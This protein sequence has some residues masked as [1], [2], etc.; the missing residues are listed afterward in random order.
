M[1]IPP[2]S[3]HERPPIVACHSVVKH[4]PRSPPRSIA[5][6]LVQFGLVS[7]PPPPKTSPGRP[8]DRLLLNPTP[9]PPPQNR[10][11]TG[12]PFFT[13]GRN[14]AADFVLE[15]PSASRLHAVLQFNGDTREV[16]EAGG[17]GGARGGEGSVPSLQ[18]NTSRA[19]VSSRR[20]SGNTVSVCNPTETQGVEVSLATHPPYIPSHFP[21]PHIL[22]SSPLRPLPLPPRAPL[23]LPSPPTPLQAFIYDPGSTHG[24]FLNK[25]RIKPRVYVPLAVGHTLRFGTSSRIHVLGGPADLMPPEGLSREQRRQLAALEAS[26]R[27]KEKQQ[28]VRGVVVEGLGAAGLGQGCGYRGAGCGDAVYGAGYVG[29]CE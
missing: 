1:H 24:T 2:P 9:H 8:L 10:S 25:Q 28:E 6:G 17:G 3:P 26:R 21:S 19:S 29:R 11:L 16:R 14:P 13:F 7:T 23:H 4:R 20:G 5:L 22:S 27:E 12:Q 15:H 18:V